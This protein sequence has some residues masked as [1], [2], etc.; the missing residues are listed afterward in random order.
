[1]ARDVLFEYLPE[2]PPQTTLGS[3]DSDWLT[4]IEQHIKE[5]SKA[6]ENFGLNKLDKVVQ[7]NSLQR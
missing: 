4:A 3:S 2:L 6:G 5:L 7:Q 1:M